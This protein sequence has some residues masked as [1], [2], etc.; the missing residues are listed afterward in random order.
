MIKNI[1]IT[2]SAKEKVIQLLKETEGASFLRISVIGGGCAGFQYKYDFVTNKADD[3][4]ILADKVLIDPVSSDLMDNAT[5]DYVETLGSAEFT[6]K[7]PNSTS[8][9]GCG[10]SFAM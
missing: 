8:R 10:N 5:I 4:L 2:D 9:C 6:I 3:D 7:N 1:N